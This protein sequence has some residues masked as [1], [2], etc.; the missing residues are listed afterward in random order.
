LAG[1]GW[2]GTL[3]LSPHRRYLKDHTSLYNPDNVQH[4]ACIASALWVVPIVVREAA[5][6][7]FCV[8]MIPVTDPDQLDLHA[9]NGFAHAMDGDAGLVH[10]IAGIYHIGTLKQ[11][12]THEDE[13]WTL[14]FSPH[15]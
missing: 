3:T 8:K 15:V 9:I 6:D 1:R 5:K 12:F 14:T 13:T 10:A 2:A 4:L 7:C 11:T